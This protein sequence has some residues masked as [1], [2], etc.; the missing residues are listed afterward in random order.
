M[1]QTKD[2]YPECKKKKSLQFIKN[3][4]TSLQ[5]VRKRLE[6]TPHKRRYKMANKHRK[7][8]LTNKTHRHLVATVYP[9]KQIKEASLVAPNFNKD[10]D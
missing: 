8:C 7:R 6:R 2:L 9:V 10:A 4:E 5:D 1:Y 3:K